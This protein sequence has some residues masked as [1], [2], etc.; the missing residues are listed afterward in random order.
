MLFGV[1]SFPGTNC[2]TESL[3][4]LR[5]VGFDAKIILWNEPEES[6]TECDGFLLAGGFS[7]EDRGRSGVVAANDHALDYLRT[8]ASA[9]KPIIGICNG[10]QVLVESGLLSDSNTPRIGLTINKRVKDKEVQGTGFYH[11]WVYLSNAA[12]KGRSPFNNFEEMTRMP[13]AH[14]EGR[15]VMDEEILKELQENDQI[16]FLYT[17]ASGKVDKEYPINPNGSYENIAG[18]CNKAGNVLAMMPHPERAGDE[19]KV[20]FDGL[21]DWMKDKKTTEPSDQ[22]LEGKEIEIKDK[23]SFDI[24]LYIKTIITDN[25]EETIRSAVRRKLDKDVHMGRMRYFGIN[26]DGDKKKEAEKIVET[27]ELANVN[28]EVVYAKI[29]DDFL[30]YVKGEGFMGIE[31]GEFMKNTQLYACDNED[32]L[33][34]A[35]TP[36][37]IH[38]K[39][40]VKNMKS[41]ICWEVEDKEKEEIINSGILANPIAN[42]IEV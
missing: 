4:A 41:A 29:G 19:A 31:A 5:R 9:G 26:L 6:F 30:Q 15:F 16:V 2:E 35:K 21:A 3:R 32:I 25:A 8:A 40:A 10:A 39:I 42:Y 22:S 17:D 7:Y 38:E 11:D 23:G 33:S 36:K 28:K 1:I 14:A 27:D 20:L 34:Q 24:E 13:V 37:L 18:L 12:D